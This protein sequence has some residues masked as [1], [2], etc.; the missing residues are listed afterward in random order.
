[1]LLA[2][3]QVTSSIIGK[4]NIDGCRK[5]C[6]GIAIFTLA[7]S[8]GFAIGCQT[9]LTPDNFVCRIVKIRNGEF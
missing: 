5:V 8:K 9:F 6:L 2:Q 3:Q 7:I 1:M 4:Q